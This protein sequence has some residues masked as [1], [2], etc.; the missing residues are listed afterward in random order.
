LI[1]DNL[2]QDRIQA[3]NSLAQCVT[4]RNELLCPN[5]MG[6]VNRRISSPIRFRNILIGEMRNAY[7]ILLWKP[8]WKTVLRGPRGRWEDNM[9]MD[10]RE[11]GLEIVNRIHLAQDRVQWRTLVNTVM[12][13]RV[14]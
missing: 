14:P 10:L 11:T 9:R 5:E 1:N 7:K 3:M 13:L 6:M 8:E 12:N 4:P 2:L